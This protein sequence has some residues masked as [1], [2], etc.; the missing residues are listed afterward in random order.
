LPLKLLK[1]I[2]DSTRASWCRWLYIEIF[3]WK[4][5][6]KAFWKVVCLIFETR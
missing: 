5:A 6:E 4:F 1:I 3:M 2:I